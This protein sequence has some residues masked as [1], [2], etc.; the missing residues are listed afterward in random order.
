MTS[1]SQMRYASRVFCHG[2]PC[3]PCARCHSMMRAAKLESLF[4]LR[5]MTR[6]VSGSVGV[7]GVIIGAMAGTPIITPPTPTESAHAEALPCARRGVGLR[8]PGNELF[9]RSA[10][11]RV[12][13]HV[14][15]RGSDVEQGVGRLAAVGEL[16]QQLALRGDRALVIAS[17]V[18]R[19]A[20]PVLR[21]RRERAA[22]IR[23]QESVESRDGAGVVAALELV[24]RAVVRALLGDAFRRISRGR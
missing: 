1:D 11:G 21:R 22:R 23:L 16:L 14:G 6:S 13:A 10:S 3:L 17:R 20:D 12:V 2:R 5:A 15:L 7:G 4:T 24:E 8:I 19:I 18:L 9:E